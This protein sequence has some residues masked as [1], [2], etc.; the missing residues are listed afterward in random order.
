M[1]STEKFH[2][3]LHLHTEFSLLDGASKISHLCKKAKEH[4]M[5]A[6][7]ITDH[8][9]MFGVYTFY[10]EAK[11]QGIKPIIG[12]EVYI[13]NGDHREKGK[14]TKL[15]HLVLLAKNDLGYKNLIKICS[16]GCINGFYYKPRISKAYLEEYA[17]GI[18][19][20]SACLGGEVNNNLLAGNYEAAKAA[21]LEYKAI[22][23]DD[24]YLEI[25]DHL[26]PEDRKVNPLMIELAQDI[27][28]KI[29]AT[30]DSHYT[31][32]EDARAHDALLCLQMQKFVS[33]FPRM[34]FSSHEYL[35]TGEEMFSLFRDHLP[36][37]L[38]TDVVYDNTMEIY[39][40]VS[41]Y[42]SFA[43][44]GMHL[45]DPELPSG[46]SFETYLK[47][48][49]YAGALERFGEISEEVS[50]RLDLELQVMADSGFASY[51]IVVWDFI[52]WARERK[53]PVG[54]GRGSAAGSLVAYAL[55]ITNIDPLKYGLLFER[56]LNPERKSMP[57]I[58]TDFCI[59][60]REEVISYVREKYG[61]DCVCQIITFNRLTSRS[62][63]KDMARVLEYPY[64][65]A[66]DL[67][68]MIPV[69]RGK[70]RTIEWMLGNHGDFK[71]YYDKSTK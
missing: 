38:I 3:P 57:D 67:A 50:S 6:L 54:P 66:E 61:E 52:R 11:K 70:P 13:V 10:H 35:K 5:P 64:A 41:D 32:K 48:I 45:P 56:F 14:R 21:A 34:R 31:N 39:E 27:G 59:D 30:N 4:N 49:S 71:K 24:F 19:A 25:Q 63:I 15:F 16:E 2:V 22:F 68:K 36:E 1:P 69:V 20:L 28:V 18:I 23:K 7:A 65:K 47:E 43:Q 58:D 26:Y 53:I 42:E 29:V 51:F 60:R 9:T 46:H 8:G 33:D 12:C 44:P 37:D 55:G 62:V 40:K 17:E